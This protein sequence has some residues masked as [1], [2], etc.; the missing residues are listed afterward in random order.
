MMIN[1]RRKT[2]MCIKNARQ[3][4]WVFEIHGVRFHSFQCMWSDILLP[5]REKKNGVQHLLLVMKIN[6]CMIKCNWMARDKWRNAMTINPFD[7]N[8]EWNWS[9]LDWAVRSSTV[10]AHLIF[11]TQWSKQFVFS[12]CLSFIWDKRRDKTL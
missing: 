6:Q 1:N 7:R 10:D 11:F 5:K 4:C 12:F 3:F 9:T 8:A 2:D